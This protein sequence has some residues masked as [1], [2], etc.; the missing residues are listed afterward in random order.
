MQE[1][2]PPA[3][4]CGISAVLGYSQMP[5][6]LLLCNLDVP[7][8]TIRKVNMQTSSFQT[9][10]QGGMGFSISSWPLAKTVSMLGQRGTISGVSLE[11]IL[12]Y[13]LQDGDPCGHFRRAL[14]HFPFP[15][16]VKEILDAYFV[17]GGIKEG[18][19]RRSAPVWSINPSKRLI[20][21]TVC[22]NFAFV[23]LAKENHENPVQINYLE[24]IAMPHIFAITGAVLAGVD[25]ITM[26]AGIPLHIPEV[27]DAL[28]EGRPVS[29]PVPVHGD[30]IK[31]HLMK[32]DPQA[33]FGA[34]LPSLKRPG[35]YPIIASNLLASVFMKKLPKGSVQGFVI[36]EPTAG[37]HNAPPRKLM[38]SESGDPLAVYGEKDVVNFARIAELGLPFWIGGSYASPEKLQWARS[39]GATGIQ[40][41]SIFALCEESGLRPDLRQRIR[42]LGFVDNL[43]VRTDMRISPTGFPFK[44][45]ELP[46]TISDPAVY[47]TRERTCDH[48]VLAILYEK[49]D[50]TIGYRCPSEPVEK[51]VA[52]GGTRA[53]TINRGCVCN[54]L[55]AT[56][57]FGDQESPLVTLGDDVSFLKKLMISP[58]GS[59][60]AEDAIRYLL[61]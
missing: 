9:I 3:G 25:Y 50:G 43:K 42:Q 56:A 30:T 21:L 6:T 4:N 37:G 45:I 57:G 35:F 39:V 11:R 38:I 41:G 48:C 26:G 31:S 16:V 18:T 15:G 51:F 60:S 36:E 22:A 59:Y 8:K 32:F 40:T 10:I 46:G 14:A 5:E 12:V 23:W 7:T 19:T 47:A 2:I 20:T 29:Y 44:V 61:S 53:D 34:K 13:V 58:E 55:F 33:F 54:G 49:P 1:I 52:K 28:A 17:E 27:L 24:K